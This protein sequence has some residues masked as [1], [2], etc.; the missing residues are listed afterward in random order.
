MAT[1][2]ALLFLSQRLPYPPN[3][4]EKIRAYHFLCHL[5]QHYSIYLGCF[6]DDPHDLAHVAAL[7]PLC[8]EICAIPINPRTRFLA[9]LP[10]WL[11]GMPLSYSLFR[12]AT[13]RSWLR[14]IST[15]IKPDYVFAYSS[16]IADYALQLG[17][18]PKHVI[19]DFVDV[20][21][22]KFEDVAALAPP[23]TRWLYA[24]EAKRVKQAEARLAVHADRLLF[25]SLPEEALFQARTHQAFTNSLAL[26]NGVDLAVFNP[27]LLEENP[28][29]DARPTLVFTGAMDYWPNIDGIL[30]FVNHVLP[31]LHAQHSTLRLAIVGSNPAPAVRALANNNIM[32]TGRVARVQ[33]YLA[34]ANLAIVPLR[35]A[36]GLQN[37]VL[38]AL[39]MGVPTL[40]SPQALNGIPATPEVHLGLAH[41]PE[42]WA[43]KT[44]DWLADPHTAKT[45]GQAGRAFVETRFD[46]AYQLNVLE[47]VVAG[48]A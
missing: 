7:S 37:K 48:T 44:L 23:T 26:E 17:Y 39:A 13:L 31:L 45:I 43:R 8:T 32:V 33:P 30:W 29:G 25:V 2:P 34:H 16:N 18:R 24:L 22:A 19:F 35:V 46:W 4:G 10:G 6:V 27:M 5:A 20:D 21:S 15:R 3:K 38:E 1:K 12:R 9:A 47:Q 41:T 14:D 36:R 40:C 11:A 28:Y 42:D